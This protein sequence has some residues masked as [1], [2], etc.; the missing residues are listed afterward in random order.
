MGQYV[1][2]LD[3]NTIALGTDTNGMSGLRRFGVERASSTTVPVEHHTASNRAVAAPRRRLAAAVETADAGAGVAGAASVAGAGVAVAAVAG[4]GAGAAAAAAAADG[5]PA[6]HR[7]WWPP[8]SAVARANRSVPVAVR[9]VV[10][11]STRGSTW[12]VRRPAR[13]VVRQ[14]AVCG[15]TVCGGTA[16][17][18]C[19]G[20]SRVG[21]AGRRDM[22][23]GWAA[24]AGSGGLA[25]E[26]AA[27]ADTGDWPMPGARGSM[28]AAAAGGMGLAAGTGNRAALALTWI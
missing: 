19:D 5:G 1:R 25:P 28:K 24:P 20:S 23:K 15:G 13:T 11:R 16:S 6:G 17:C 2:F 27:A 7:A 14:A 22:H 26:A 3:W 21:D 12:A 10:A 9:A 18:D 4:A 8:T